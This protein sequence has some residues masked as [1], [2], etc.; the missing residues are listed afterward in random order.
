MMTERTGAQLFGSLTS[1]VLAKRSQRSYKT[2]REMRL[3]PTLSLARQ[4]VLAPVLLAQW[5]FESRDGAPPEAAAFIEKQIR[6]IRIHL[7]RTAMLG[8]IDF[9][10][11]PYEKVYSYDGQRYTLQKLKPLLQDLTDIL[12]DQE[13]GAYIGLRQRTTSKETTLEVAET[14]LVS[15]DV[16]GTDWYGQ[17]VMEVAR[18]P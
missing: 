18:K 13:T 7:L 16:E 2:Y 4:L 6:P 9:G 14:F 17:P 8:C 3:D 1:N 10:W 15:L 12:V 5:S 11:Q